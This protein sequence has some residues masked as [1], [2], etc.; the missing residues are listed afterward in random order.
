MKADNLNASNAIVLS[1]GEDFDDVTLPGTYQLLWY[2]SGAE[3]TPTGGNACQLAVSRIAENVILQ[4]CTVWRGNRVYETYQRIRE[5][6]VWTAWS[7]P[8]PAPAEVSFAY[9][10]GA[11]N[12]GT[13]LYCI[14]QLV[15]GVIEI[16]L[17]TVN[18]SGWVE[19][20]QIDTPPKDRINGRTS[21]F[22]TGPARD[23]LITSAGVFQAYITADDGGRAMNIPIAY[24]V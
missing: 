20:M 13:H 9:K 14:G 21:A 5:D 15:C 24:I 16:R 6:G 10:N 12:Y 19:L 23:W 4:T 11:S 3:N 2:D 7:Q 17:P 1:A 22:A 8:M 18:S